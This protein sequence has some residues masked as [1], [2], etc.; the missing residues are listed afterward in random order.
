MLFGVTGDAMSDGNIITFAHDGSAV[1]DAPGGRVRLVRNHENRD[2]GGPPLAATNAYDPAGGGG[3]TTTELEF[4]S[5]G[6][7]VVVK[8]FV[9]LNGTIVNCAGGITPAGS[10]ISSEET[11]ETALALSMATT[12]RSP[13][14]LRVRWCRCR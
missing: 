3:C 2:P 8:D 7:P 10:W 4:A 12:S 6:T 11:T 14:A 5:D 13:P 1:F 9:S